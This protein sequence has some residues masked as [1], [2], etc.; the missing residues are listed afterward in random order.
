MKPRNLRTP[1]SRVAEAGYGAAEWKS[2]E[3][4]DFPALLLAAEGGADRL[5]VLVLR[6]QG[7]AARRTA[8][9]VAEYLPHLFRL[10]TTQGELLEQV[11]GGMLFIF[12]C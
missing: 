4:V 9:Q 1:G 8:V 5:D 7:L 12:H 3:S 11:H 2:A 6:T 10:Q